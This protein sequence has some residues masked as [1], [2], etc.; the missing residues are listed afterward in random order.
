MKSSFIRCTLCL[1]GFVFFCETQCQGRTIA[2]AGAKMQIQLGDAGSAAKS[3]PA[4]TQL[5]II[6]DNGESLDVR[7]SGGVT[8]T[9][10]RSDVTIREIEDKTTSETVAPSPAITP[11]QSNPAPA[12]PAATIPAPTNTPPGGS[13]NVTFENLNQVLNI[14]LLASDNLW[15]EDASVVASRIHLPEESKT[16]T[17]SSFRSYPKK[18]ERILG[19]RPY[20]LALYAS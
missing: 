1:F 13:G 11:A 18:E 17:Q 12:N 14:P 16:E 9:I 10:A 2:I 15:N 3:L 6:K 7:D 20:S 8:G 19:A 5:D 4:G